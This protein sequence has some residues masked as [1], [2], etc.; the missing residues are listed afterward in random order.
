MILDARPGIKRASYVE[1]MGRISKQQ[2]KS[3]LT[4]GAKVTESDDLSADQVSSLL[5]TITIFFAAEKAS[6]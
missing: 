6:D 1:V 4:K 2:A 3:K 5:E